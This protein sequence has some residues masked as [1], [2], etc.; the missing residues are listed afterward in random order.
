MFED[1]KKFVNNQYKKFQ[2]HRVHNRFYMAFQ[3]YAEFPFQ[4]GLTYLGHIGCKKLK[5]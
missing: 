1:G 5:N 3:I 2:K 4:L